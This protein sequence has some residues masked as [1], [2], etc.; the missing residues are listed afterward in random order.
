MYISHR[1][2]DTELLSLPLH[3]DFLVQPVVV[4]LFSALNAYC[5]FVLDIFHNS[6]LGFIEY[7]DFIEY[8]V[9]ILSLRK[10]H[11]RF[12]ALLQTTIVHS[13]L[14]LGGPPLCESTAFCLPIYQVKD[15]GLVLVCVILKEM[16]IYIHLQIFVAIFSLPL[17]VIF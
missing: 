11:L 16:T 4:T 1:S 15:F 12:T 8:T 5:V 10:L 9:W 6:V 7:S 17:F 3:P 2:Q 13:R 14:V